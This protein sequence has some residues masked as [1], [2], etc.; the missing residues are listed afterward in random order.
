MD[1][2]AR[3]LLDVLA[4]FFS[5]LKPCPELLRKVSDIKGVWIIL[6]LAMN[7]GK[8]ALHPCIAKVKDGG[9]IAIGRDT[10]G[11]C[12]GAGTMMVDMVATKHMQ[13]PLLCVLR[14]WAN[15]AWT[16]LLF[17]NQLNGALVLVLLLLLV[18]IASV[19]S[20][21]RRGQSPALLV[22]CQPNS[23]RHQ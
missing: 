13:Q 16:A 14:T 18:I 3:E 19:P 12:R 7:G 17:L 21:G 1:G 11:T 22:L 23:L 9:K 5:T 20:M 4:F 10:P 2:F 15:I 8:G 6:V